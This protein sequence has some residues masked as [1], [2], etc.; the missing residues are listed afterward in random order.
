M[1]F[2]FGIYAGGPAGTDT[3]AVLG[4]SRPVL[5]DQGAAMLSELA[6]DASFLLRAYTGYDGTT[7]ASEVTT[8]P[9]DAAEHV[10]ARHRL[11]L[12]ICYRD[13]DGDLAGWLGFVEAL[14]DRFADRLGSVQVT[15]EANLCHPPGDGEIP[16]VLDA[17]TEG[18]VVAAAALARAGI[19]VP[20]GFNAAPSRGNGD[21]FWSALGT[22]IAG[23]ADFQAAL[24]WVGLD[25][26]PDVWQP[27]PHPRLGS[28]LVGLLEQLRHVHLPVAGIGPQVPL[29]VCEH[30]WPTG[31]GRSPAQQ[32]FVVDTV[33]EAVTASAG[34]LGVEAYEH[35]SLLDADTSS[36]SLFGHFGLL[37]DTWK[38]KPAFAAYRRR[39][40]ELA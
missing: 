5:G 28:A 29:R 38:P 39:I 15:E 37:D 27:I 4:A 10:S 32:A 9:I 22:K 25:A 2:T 20:V 40:A 24:G 6:G 21:P 34:R 7:P 30:G 16:G 35:F 31:P 13:R 8:S 36:D 14:V 3:G 11:D 18:I 17:L 1:T 12:V 26:F 23:R 19:D 33:I